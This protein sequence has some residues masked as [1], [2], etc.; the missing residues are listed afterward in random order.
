MSNLKQI[1]ES[2]GLSQSQLANA[3]GINCRMLQFYEQGA[4]D[5]NGAKAITVYKLAT[6]L[7]V[8]VEDILNL[9]EVHYEYKGI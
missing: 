1:R 4:R 5:I 3:A 2:R 6:A 9:D 7:Q 8:G